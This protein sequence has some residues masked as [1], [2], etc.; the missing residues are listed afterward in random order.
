MLQAF[1]PLPQLQLKEA[2][3]ES[4]IYDTSFCCSQVKRAVESSRKGPVL[5]PR[6]SRCAVNGCEDLPRLIN[7]QMLIPAVIKVLRLPELSNF[8]PSQALQ[9]WDDLSHLRDISSKNTTR[10]TGGKLVR[11]DLLADSGGH[12]QR[13]WIIADVLS[14]ICINVD[15]SG[16]P[17]EANLSPHF[18]SVTDSLISQSFARIIS[19]RFEFPRWRCVRI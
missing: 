8:R 16:K 15:F 11:W 7:S 12:L 3:E 13:Y 17:Q 10:L 18:E 19:D 2:Q 5:Q 14:P 1:V 6:W 9:Y 4:N